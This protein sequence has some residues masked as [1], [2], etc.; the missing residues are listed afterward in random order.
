[1]VLALRLRAVRRRLTLKETKEE[2]GDQKA[3]VTFHKTFVEIRKIILGSNREPY[4]AKW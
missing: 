1:M 2:T 4:L 3:L